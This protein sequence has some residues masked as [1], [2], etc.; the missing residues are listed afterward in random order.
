LPPPRGPE[1]P[2]PHSGRVSQVYLRLRELIVRG[3]L[4]PGARVI[5]TE[6]AQRLEVSRTPVR[7]ALQRLMQEG[8][9]VSTGPGKQLRLAVSPLTEDDA[10]ELFGIVGELE[11]LAARNLA[12][13]GEGARHAVADELAGLD[14]DLLAAAEMVP[15]RPD[16]VFEIFTLFHRRLV[17]EGAGPRLQLLHRSVKPQ[18]DRYRRLYSSTQFRRIRMSVREHAAILD[19]IREGDPDRAQRAVRA[20]WTNAAD[21]LGA[22]IRSAGELGSW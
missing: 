17:E 22:T 8:Y 11:G 19:A 5:E 12:R 13:T 18:A 7:A 9:V 2:A 3:H 1:A 15:P 16:R 4:G 21:R 14:R 20:N 6:L 10:R